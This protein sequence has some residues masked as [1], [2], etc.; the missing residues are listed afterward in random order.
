MLDTI[1]G[2]D[3]LADIQQTL[4]R[5]WACHEV[6]EI[7]RLHMDLAAGEIGANIIE[8]S[9]DGQPVHMRMSIELTADTVRAVFTDDGHPAPMDLS[10]VQMPDEMS[11]YGRGL[12][13]AFRV[14][15]E[16]SYRRDTEGNHWIL[17]HS[18]T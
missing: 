6:P 4:D 12:A 10:R 7:V 14:L 17:V 9:G 1:T 13:I 3:T 16:L 2:P 5:A 11:E 8:H 18:R 15:D